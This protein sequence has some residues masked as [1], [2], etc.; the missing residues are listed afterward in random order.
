[1]IYNIYYRIMSLQKTKSNTLRNI[2]TERLHNSTSNRPGE[3]ARLELHND[4]L[5][6]LLQLLSN[7]FIQ[8]EEIAKLSTL[9][10]G[11]QQV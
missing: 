7:R 6:S 4:V 1:M 5:Q 2:A 10:V 3:I 11:T 8:Q 9:L